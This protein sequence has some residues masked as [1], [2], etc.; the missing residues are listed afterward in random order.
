[1]QSTDTYRP[2]PR[3]NPRIFVE[4]FK[5]AFPWDIFLYL[6]Q[7]LPQRTLRSYVLV[8]KVLGEGARL[9]LYTD[10]TLSTSQQVK[11]LKCTLVSHPSLCKYIR[12]LRLVSSSA[13]IHLPDCALFPQLRE[14]VYP[15]D[16]SDNLWNSHFRPKGGDF[17]LTKITIQYL[18][19]L[20][21]LIQAISSIGS[22]TSLSCGTLVSHR[23]CTVP[24]D[25]I[26]CNLKS[27][28]VGASN[29]SAWFVSG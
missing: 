13:A 10:V 20:D 15:E 27:L 3:R 4:P 7:F 26:R 21:T 2:L 29:S 8:C 28:C 23:P 14:I 5:R 16:W 1:M 18:M 6:A 17:V 24:A 11:A 22:L 12:V 9:W 19:E 25:Q